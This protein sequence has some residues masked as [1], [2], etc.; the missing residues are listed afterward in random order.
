MKAEQLLHSAHSVHVSGSLAAHGDAR[1]DNIMVLVEAGNVKQMKLIDMDGAGIIGNAYY[2]VMLNAKTILWPAG[3]GP[4][5]PLQQKHDVELLHLQV[6]SHFH[7]LR[8]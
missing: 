6:D 8:V 7:T 2:S 1:P 5:Q 4:G 3:A